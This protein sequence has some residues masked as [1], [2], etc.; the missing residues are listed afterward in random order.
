MKINNSSNL[1]LNLKNLT[2]SGNVSLGSTS[3]DVITM[4]GSV[5]FNERVT[6]DKKVIMNTVQRIST[7][8]TLNNTAPPTVAKDYRYY[9]INTSTSNSYCRLWESGVSG[10]DGATITILNRGSAPVKIYGFG[11]YTISN[12][13]LSWSSP[14]NSQ[15]IMDHKGNIVDY[16]TLGQ[17]DWVELVE[18]PYLSLFGWIITETVGI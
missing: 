1:V 14:T 2:T 16:I 7:I 17:T 5:T 10:H 18:S 11:G 6:I 8:S 13:P 3:T 12:S 4:N 9:Y 15:R